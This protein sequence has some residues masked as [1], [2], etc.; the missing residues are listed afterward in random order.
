M[1]C[2]FWLLGFFL[3]RCGDA[4][5]RYLAIT[6]TIGPGEEREYA[7]EGTTRRMALD[8]LQGNSLQCIHPSRGRLSEA[9]LV[10]MPTIQD[11]NSQT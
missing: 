10:R 1:E 4:R 7:R 3:L 11:P 9:R 5:T 2:L 6:Q 8:S